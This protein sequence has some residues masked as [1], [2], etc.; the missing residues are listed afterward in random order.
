MS[1]SISI[2]V[3]ADMD[4]E[5]ITLQVTGCLTLHTRSVLAA[6]ID[7]ARSLGPAAPIVVDAR[8][9]Q[10][11]DA[12]ALQLLRSAVDNAEALST[13]WDRPVPVRFLTATPLP[14]CPLDEAATT[15]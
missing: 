4:S 10:H 13:L 2:L 6:Q 1:H 5:S 15:A 8:D 9:A 14:R 3:R 12:I 7:K 11:V